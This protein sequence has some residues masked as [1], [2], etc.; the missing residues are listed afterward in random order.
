MEDKHF[1]GHY[2]GDKLSLSPFAKFLRVVM[3]IIIGVYCFLGFLGATIDEHKVSAFV[4]ILVGLNMILLLFGL[5]IPGLVIRGYNRTR[6][7][8]LAVYGSSFI[9]LIIMF[10]VTAPSNIAPTIDINQKAVPVTTTQNAS[11]SME[12]YK[13]SAKHIQYIELA[14]NPDN[15]K[16]KRVVYT[17]KVI[18]TLELG[19]GNNVVLL[20]NVTKGEYGLWD[21]TV[22]VNYR[23]SD[24]ESRIL[25][26]D[27]IT[28]WGTVKGL[29]TYKSV[30][31]A[32]ITI[33]EIDAKY[34]TIDGHEE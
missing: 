19:I 2:S 24:G 29:K 11:E 28:L 23:R 5:I 12:E 22:Y 34:I 21:D 13:S 14:R 27:I 8:V 6:R 1:K 32:K 4:L 3:F 18:Q 33:P 15:Y 31:G 20:V 9:L 10:I 30:L 26:N 17:G 16:T 25:E 7:K